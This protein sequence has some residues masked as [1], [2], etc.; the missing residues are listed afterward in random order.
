LNVF[1]T[2]TTRGSISQI[3]AVRE[4]IETPKSVFQAP[5]PS[6]ST[7]V[8]ATPKVSNSHVPISRSNIGQVPRT[9]ESTPVNTGNVT[10]WQPPK[11]KAASVTMYDS[12]QHVIPQ[13]QPPPPPKPQTAAATSTVPTTL[14]TEHIKQVIPG[15]L[16]DFYD[17]PFDLLYDRQDK[18][19]TNSKQASQVPTKVQTPQVPM[20]SQTQRQVLHTPSQEQPMFSTTFQP[21]NHFKNIQDPLTEIFNKTFTEYSSPSLS[22]KSNGNL[23]ALPPF[24][25]GHLIKRVQ[26]DYLREI[27]PFVSSVK[28][29]D[30]DRE[31]GQSLDDVGFTTPISVRRGFRRQAD[32]LLRR[33]A[34]RK[35]REKPS[36]IDRSDDSDSDE[37]DQIHDLPTSHR[38]YGLEK[39]S[40]KQSFTSNTYTTTTSTDYDEQ[41]YDSYLK[42]KSRQVHDQATS[43]PRKSTRRIVNE[44]YMIIVDILLAS[45]NPRKA[46]LPIEVKTSKSIA[47]ESKQ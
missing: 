15:Q 2:S 22:T 9:Q 28:F 29:I 20:Q 11:Q 34:G 45:E 25:L 10:S 14:K 47:N 18:R 24:D 17:D 41:K 5:K 46:S 19:S 21:A 6:P 36:A 44:C 39:N 13:P 26:Q 33:S 35:H 23:P 1:T 16:Y 12:F 30:K 3:S 32:D 43:P 38:N 37:Y 8:A 7:A 42:S 27:Q 40:S 31:Y 4:R